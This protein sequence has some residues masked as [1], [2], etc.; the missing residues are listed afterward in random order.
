MPDGI[1]QVE[2]A[3]RVGGVEPAERAPELGGSEDVRRAVELP[4][5]KLFGRRVRLLD[6]RRELAS[7]VPQQA[8][9]GPRL[10]RLDREHGDGSA[11]ATMSGHELLEY[12]ACEQRRVSGHHENVSVEILEAVARRRDRVAGAARLLLDGQLELIRERGA[13]LFLALR[14]DD[15]D[16]RRRVERPYRI[17]D[18][19]EQPPAEQR[20]QVLRPVRLHAGPQARGHHDCC[21]RLGHEGRVSAGA[22][23]F[24]PPV[25]GPK[26]AALPLGYAPPGTE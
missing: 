11:L 6:D 3:L 18:P 17:E 22:G 5:R 15:D 13:K 21:E 9:V 16:T 1:G 19:V 14:R 8:S 2:L 12:V 23:G 25:T 24:E 10:V 26:P 7:L 4:H 20:M